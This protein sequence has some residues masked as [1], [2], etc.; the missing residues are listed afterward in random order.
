LTCPELTWQQLLG[1][2][3]SLDESLLADAGYWAIAPE[4]GICG[5]RGSGEDYGDA[6]CC[7]H[8]LDGGDSA[9]V[10]G[11]TAWACPVAMACGGGVGSG[12]GG[13][14]AEAAAAI[15]GM[16][17]GF[18]LPVATDYYQEEYLDGGWRGWQPL[19]G[20]GARGSSNATEAVA[21]AETFMAGPVGVGAGRAQQVPPRLSPGLSG[22]TRSVASTSMSPP[23]DRNAAVRAASQPAAATVW[24][25]DSPSRG[26]H[27][28]GLVGGDAATNCSV[29][30]SEYLMFT[31]RGGRD[32]WADR[33]ASSGQ[34]SSLRPVSHR[35]MV[36]GCMDT[37]DDQQGVVADR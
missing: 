33:A 31:G 24:P 11:S 32:G 1:P 3:P 10:D 9:C 30:L 16:A 19:A 20:A 36:V 15:G 18:H 28:P 25:R 7:V 17:S 23:T 27:P 29:C 4:P 14:F 6:A 37:A 35:L 2:S 8:F 34:P 5:G 26:M 13:A 22:T 12:A 21:H